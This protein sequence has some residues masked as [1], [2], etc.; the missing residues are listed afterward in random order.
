MYYI[1]KEEYLWRSVHKRRSDCDR[2]IV[3]L[4]Q[5]W[6]AWSGRVILLQV[7][8]IWY[9][10]EIV[11]ALA[12]NT[13]SYFYWIKFSRR[14]YGSANDNSYETI[15]CSQDIWVRTLIVQHICR[16]Y[17]VG[18]LTM[19]GILKGNR[20]I[21]QQLFHWD[22]WNGIFMMLQVKPWQVL[23]YQYRYVLYHISTGWY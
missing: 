19:W 17:H 12:I 5:N 9:M 21:L 8:P 20:K 18:I 22:K 11:I 14:L 13:R 23:W 4:L 2:K 15:L 7:K 10:V 3:Q 16:N 6:A 1:P